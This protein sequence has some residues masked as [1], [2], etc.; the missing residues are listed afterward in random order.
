MVSSCFDDRLSERIPPG[1]TELSVAVETINLSQEMDYL[2]P[3]RFRN[4]SN[5]EKFEH[6]TMLLQSFLIPEAHRANIF[7]SK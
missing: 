2:R 4:L 5:D 7:F 6:V 3:P 1:Y